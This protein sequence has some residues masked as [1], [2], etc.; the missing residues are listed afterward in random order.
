MKRS[1]V[2]LLAAALVPHLLLAQA[3]AGARIEGVVTDSVYARPASGATVLL[4][5]I[6]PEP[7]EFRSTLTDDKGRFRFDSLVAGRYSIAYATD[8]LDSLNVA[9]P[10]REVALSVGQTARMNFATPSGATLRRA[11]CPGLVLPRGQ[12]AVVGKVSDADTDQP[13]TTARVAVSWNELSVDKT[14]LRSITT[15]HGG[16]VPVDSVGRYHLCGVPTATYLMLQVQD[17]GRAGSV[18]TV[19]V[20]DEGGVLVRDLSLS[21]ASARSIAALDST[22][23]A[24][25]ASGTVT[26]PL[27]TGNATL[28]GVVLGPGGQPLPGAQVR[29][30]D[31]AGVVRSDSAGRF[32]LANLPAGSQVLET[33][34]VGY[35]LGRVPVELRGGRAVTTTVTLTRIVSL[36]SIRIVARRSR[37]QEFEQRRQSSAGFGKFLDQAEIEKRNAFETSDLLSMMPGFKVMGG[38]FD[39]KVISSRGFNFDGRPCESNVVINGI[40]HQDINLIDPSSVGAVE[41]YPG[42]AGAPPQ[43]DADCG[44]VLIWTKR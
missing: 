34:R 38:G 42:R 24:A 20:G 12:G 36:D 19:T 33:R 5:R 44:V 13:L 28:N 10:P 2:L 25:A 9:I 14:T 21:A 1:I 41:A 7:S 16:V 26:Q 23:V 15:P 3:P 27:L 29:V 43:Y 31:A 18:L 37:Y 35:L 39:A 11:A 8:Y 17:S 40:Q 30:R 22:A 4:T 6:T 32:M